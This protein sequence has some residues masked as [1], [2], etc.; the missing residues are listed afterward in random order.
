M[1]D[2]RHRVGNQGRTLAGVAAQAPC[3]LRITTNSEQP[4]AGI[5]A[6][7]LESLVGLDQVVHETALW[8]ASTQS[9]HEQR[10]HLVLHTLA[11]LR[12]G[13]LS[14]PS[15]EQAANKLLACADQW[16]DGYTHTRFALVSV[17]DGDTYRIIEGHIYPRFMPASTPACVIDAD[18]ALAG[19]FELPGGLSDG[20]KLLSDLA[21]GGS[22]SMGNRRFVFHVGSS[23]GAMFELLHRSGL[24]DGRRIPTI[25]LSG[26]RR[27]ELFDKAELDWQLKGSKLAIDGLWDVAEMAGIALVGGDTCILE[28]AP[29]NI[30]EFD[31]RSRVNGEMAELDLFMSPKLETAKAGV[32]F[33]VFEQRRV[34][35]RGY[36]AGSDIQWDGTSGVPR[37]SLRIPVPAGAVVQAF[38]S[39]D[40]CAQQQYY[41]V[42][43]SAL[44][45]A[46]RAAYGT[47][48][49][50][51][52]VL[53]DMLF[54]KKARRKDPQRDFETG[55]ANLLYIVGFAAVNLGGT[56]RIQDAADILCSTPSGHYALVECTLLQPD[57]D[58]KLSKLYTRTQTL[59]SELD[60]QGLQGRRLIPVIV[61]ALRHA[62]VPQTEIDKARGLG[63]ALLTREDLESA[64]QRSMF[65]EVAEV[66]YTEGL[67]ALTA[68]KAAT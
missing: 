9:G 21:A 16:K 68:P 20:L 26:G 31:N 32:A 42:D 13:L 25:Q 30:V 29:L 2:A 28:Y 58:D 8:A 50:N 65:G 51:L 46:R 22:V 67:T 52:E 1:I 41:A 53:E 19:Q 6:R 55:M 59:R 12:I 24:V 62:D 15:F 49:K 44:P 64:M 18:I 43:P 48:D 57:R 10:S 11:P 56:P 3:T 40:S 45:N 5:F 7:V 39:Y 38:A 4:A 66:I 34:I 54:E 23:P 33:K 35:K 61:T 60:R 63:I 27:S 17:R 47:F 14:F 37:V 36:V